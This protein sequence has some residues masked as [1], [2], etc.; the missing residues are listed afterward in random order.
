MKK[1]FYVIIFLLMVDVDGSTSTVCE[2]FELIKHRNI[3]YNQLVCSGIKEENKGGKEKAIRFFEKALEEELFEEP[4]VYLFPRLAILYAKLGDLKTARM[5]LDKAR[6]AIEVLFGI[7]KCDLDYLYSPRVDLS[8]LYDGKKIGIVNNGKR[9]E[10]S[11]AKS[12][13][14]EVCQENLIDTFAIK[15]SLD[16]IVMSPFVQ[17]YQHAYKLIESRKEN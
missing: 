11:V 16:L 12:L 8:K 10:T 6:L 4:N 17:K 5:Y 3:A 9:I 2:S 13:F 15:P 7:S 14:F 1:I